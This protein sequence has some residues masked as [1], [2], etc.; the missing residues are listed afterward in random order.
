MA[1]SSVSADFMK[2]RI[3]MFVDFMGWV[4]EEGKNMDGS[5]QSS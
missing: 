4:Q 5:V 2:R 3:L 1:I